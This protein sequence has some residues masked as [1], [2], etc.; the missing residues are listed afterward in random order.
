MKFVTALVLAICVSVPVSAGTYE[1][2]VFMVDGKPF[3]P[4]GGWE[5]GEITP[6]EISD[7]GMN[8]TLR[9]VSGDS[10][11]H[12]YME[13]MAAA[14]VNVMVYVPAG[15]E[16]Y[17]RKYLENVATL[18][19]HGNVLV[20]CVGDD[21]NEDKLPGLSGNVSVLRELRPD[22]PTLGDFW[23]DD[24]KLA[25]EFDQYVDINSQYTYPIPELDFDYFREFFAEQRRKHGDPIWTYIQNFQGGGD[26]IRLSIGVNDGSGMVPD[27]EQIRLMAYLSANSGVRGITFF[28]Q[29][30]LLQLPEYAA[31]VALF[32]REAR[33][34]N[35]YLAAGI[36]S[37]R[38]SSSDPDIDA[39]S[40][41]Y[42][43]TTVVSAALARDHYH[44]WID[45]AIIHDVTIDVPWAQQSTPK[46]LLIDMP[47]TVKCDIHR[48]SPDTIRVT[49]P[50]LEMAGFIM[51][52]SDDD[53][54][55]RVASETVEQASLLAPLAVTG[56]ASHAR[57]IQDTLFRNG[58]SH[59]YVHIEDLRELSQLM[60]NLPKS[61]AADRNL[62]VVREWRAANRIC[63]K[64]INDL[65][66]SATSK[67]S[68]IPPAQI[69]YLESPYSL[70]N[71]TNL[72]NAPDP[73][74]PW[75]RVS[76]YLVAGPFPLLAAEV[77]PDLHPAEGFVTPYPPETNPDVRARFE[78]VDG[79][80]GWRTAS[81]DITGLLNLL[82]QFKTTVDVVAYA[83]V[84]VTAPR[85]MET[86]MMWRTNDGARLWVNDELILDEHVGRWINMKVLEAQ[87]IT[88]RKGPNTFLAK[89]ENFGRNWRVYLAF[90]DPDREL[91]YTTE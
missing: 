31:E 60:R 34:V 91:I 82:A 52:S 62:D 72:A 22:I 19:S 42:G 49:I 70:F 81:A 21:L 28:S 16:P 78:T 15:T 79:M 10:A 45:E 83:R 74:D 39:V 4:L 61:L 88:L 30:Q 36:L 14:G 1:N 32:C 8:A 11:G 29:L 17:S 77:E 6:E 59:L 20:W 35:E 58:F 67:E 57:K 80:G 26:G 24:E 9:I 54:L 69:K 85:D 63:R 71:I 73:G 53:E 51:L 65:M 44:R 76:D 5:V 46:A 66:V 64:L 50:R 37:E 90:D 89:V 75:H 38:L 7:L 23:I 55:A 87:P 56:A 27:P 86:S 18:T 84:V 3:F 43:N 47:G 25:T 2:G 12:A 68:V 40:F 41:T 48:I 33:I 13:G